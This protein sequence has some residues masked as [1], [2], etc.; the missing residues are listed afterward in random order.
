VADFVAM[1]L[2]NNRDID[3]VHVRDLDSAGLIRCKS[4]RDC[5]M[6]FGEA[7]RDSE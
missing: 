5:R 4:K 1:K 2:S 6:F 7:E 3:R